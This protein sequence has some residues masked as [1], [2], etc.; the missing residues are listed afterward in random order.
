M[1]RE[2]S[3]GTHGIFNSNVGDASGES[4]ASAFGTQENQ[5]IIEEEKQEEYP[6]FNKSNRRLDNYHLSF[7]SR[8]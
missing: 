8:L 6:D 2:I 4:Y 7:S 1:Q 3:N 5:P